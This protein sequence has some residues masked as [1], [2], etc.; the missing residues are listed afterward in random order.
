[1]N[2]C[3]IVCEYNPF[4]NGHLYQINAL[5]KELGFDAVVGVMSGNW[6]QRGDVAIFDKKV[7][8][9]AAVMNGMDLVIELPSVYAMQSAEIFSRNA[10]YILNSLGNVNS[11]AFGAE[12]DDIG[13]LKKIAKLLAEEPLIF[14]NIIRSEMKQ[15]IPYF[16]ARSNAIGKILG[17]KYKE[18]ASMPNNILGIEYIKALIK[19]GST[20]NPVA[21]RRTGVGH[22][23]YK[24]RDNITSAT[25]IRNLLFKG[26]IEYQEYIPKNCLELYNKAAIHDISKLDNAVISHFLKSSANNIKNTPDVSEGLENK[27]IKSA[28]NSKSIAE[29]YDSIKSKRYAHSRIRRIVLNS[30]LGITEDDVSSSPKYV[31]VLNFTEVGQKVLHKCKNTHSLP[32]GSNRNIVKGNDFSEAVWDRELIFDRIYNLCE[33]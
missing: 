30:F 29:L 31:K 26:I 10:V 23:E 4:H 13:I 19:L 9:K 16:I 1:M 7:R 17:S 12:T 33:I 8:A 21:I 14:K 25:S 15:G 11:I 24:T 6:V 32:I 22:D 18:A 28:Q 20:M 27:M 5:K 3:G 2:I